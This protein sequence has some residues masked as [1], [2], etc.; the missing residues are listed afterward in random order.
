[1]NTYIRIENNIIVEKIECENIENI[2]H[3]DI[4]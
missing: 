2:F 3:P 1:M 4:Q